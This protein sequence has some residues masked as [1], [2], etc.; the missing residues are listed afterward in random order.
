MLID[1]HVHVGTSLQLKDWL[2]QWFQQFHQEDIF[3]LMDKVSTPEGLLEL[4]KS[5]GLDYLVILAE[6][7]FAGTVTNEFVAGLAQKVDGALAFANIN[8]TMEPNP[9]E[10]LEY[11]V[12]DL[13]CRGLKLLP[14]YHHFYLND[15]KLYPIYAKAQELDI[16]V[17]IH[18]GSSAFSAS[19]IK[20]GQP[21]FLDD[22]A[23]DFPQLNI[24]MAHSGRGCWYQEAFFL[25]KH[26]SNIYMEV[27]GLPPKNLLKY[28]PDLERIYQKVIFGSDWP[29]IK[30]I[31]ENI[32]QIKKLPISDAA[33]EAILGNNAARV[34][35]LK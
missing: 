1:F 20:Y 15:P 8:P 10:T 16:P 6:I 29:S 19:R 21:I 23:S 28:F 35:R 31:K 24:I 14:T 17:L 3:E 30:M 2:L 33:K 27:S 25:A 4:K 11:L 32:N 18:T 22:V 9:V 5:A 26:H 7:D 13:G 12:K 34:L